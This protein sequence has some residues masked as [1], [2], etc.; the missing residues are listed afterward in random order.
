[1]VEEVAVGERLTFWWWADGGESSR[2]TFELAPAWAARGC[3]HRDPGRADGAG[4]AACPRVR[5]GVSASRG[6]RDPTARV[7]ELLAS[8]KHDGD[9]ESPPSCPSPPGGGPSTR[10]PQDAGPCTAQRKRRER[11]FSPTPAPRERFFVEAAVGGH[12]EDRLRALERYVRGVMPRAIETSGL[13][14]K[15]WHSGHST[16]R[17]ARE[18]GP[19]FS[20]C[21]A[22]TAR[23]RRRSCGSW[24]RLLTPDCCSARVDGLRRG[25]ATRPQLRRRIGPG[26]AVRG[27]DEGLHRPRE[28]RALS[29]A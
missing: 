5:A 24:R 20:G 7:M 14:K 28:P 27:V 6:P 13:S 12:G 29:R 17:P 2:V 18:H 4:Y 26:R 25:A 1:M 16:R 23:A 21:S 11:R 8:G 10:G 3:G 19:R 22:P 9:R 15:L